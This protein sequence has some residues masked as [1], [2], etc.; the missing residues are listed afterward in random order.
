MVSIHL[1]VFLRVHD[2]LEPE[3]DHLEGEGGGDAVDQGE[4]MA[5]LN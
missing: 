1:R 4:P 5:G 2:L 3:L